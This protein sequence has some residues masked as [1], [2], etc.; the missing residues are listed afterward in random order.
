MAGFAKPL[1]AVQILFI[2]F[3]MDGILAI[4]L[5]VEPPEKGIMQRK[6]RTKSEGILNKLSVSYIGVIGIWIGVICFAVFMSYSNDEFIQ[7][8]MRNLGISMQYAYEP[9]RYAMT[10]FFVT[11]IMARIFNVFATRS[12]TESF[13]K[14]GIKNNNTLIVELVL[15]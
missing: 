3:V 14:Y 5:G 8:V 7:N 10:M 4:T 11:L 6:P 15:L 12:I 9:H 1:T 13:F 2:N